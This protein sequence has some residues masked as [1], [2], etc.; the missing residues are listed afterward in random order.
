M[1]RMNFGLIRTQKIKFSVK[2]CTVDV[3]K[4][5]ASCGSHLLKKSFTENFIFCAVLIAQDL[6]IELLSILPLSLWISHIDFCVLFQS[7]ID[8]KPN[9]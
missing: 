1:Q 9:L 5:A 6:N 2:I 7:R 3:T 4:S 8:I